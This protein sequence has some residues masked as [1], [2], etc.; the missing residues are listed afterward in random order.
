MET[1]E[2]KRLN[3]GLRVGM[4]VVI[5]I[6]CLASATGW[7]SSDPDLWTPFVCIIAVMGVGTRGGVLEALPFVIIEACV[8]FWLGVATFSGH[9]D[10]IWAASVAVSILA[11]GKI[12]LLELARQNDVRTKRDED[13]K[14]EAVAET[15]AA[16]KKASD[17]P[18]PA[19]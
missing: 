4:L 17:P 10:F 8:V 18:P 3:N 16:S 15:E 13:A 6:V 11:L 9:R 12:S 1:E 14:A 5:A 7:S 19:A 2:R